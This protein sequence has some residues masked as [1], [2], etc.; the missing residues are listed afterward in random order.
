VHATL[1]RNKAQGTRGGAVFAESG[2]TAYACIVAGQPDNG[3]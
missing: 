3:K 1:R 2:K